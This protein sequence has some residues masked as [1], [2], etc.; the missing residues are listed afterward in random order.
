MT[1]Y[2]VMGHIYVQLTL[3]MVVTMHSKKKKGWKHVLIL[4]YV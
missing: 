2:R 3:Y 4:L 1:L